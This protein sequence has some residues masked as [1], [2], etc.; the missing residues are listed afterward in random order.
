MGLSPP[1]TTLAVEGNGDVTCRK[2]IRKSRTIEVIVSI[3]ETARMSFVRVIRY[4]T[5][6]RTS[7]LL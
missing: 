6:R 5:L 3:L 2:D 7:F 4:L 1:Q